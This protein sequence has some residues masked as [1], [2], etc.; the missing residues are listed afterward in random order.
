MSAS[1]IARTP[2]RFN[3]HISRRAPVPDFMGRWL[4]R[5]SLLPVIIHV[6]GF[7]SEGVGG[8]LGWCMVQN[9]MA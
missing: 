1:T 4:K 9:D 5:S 8:A 6:G 2:D 3:L 7:H